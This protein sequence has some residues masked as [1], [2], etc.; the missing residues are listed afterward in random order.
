MEI[1]YHD[2]VKE[3]LSLIPSQVSADF[4][5]GSIKDVI[6]L[7]STEGVKVFVPSNWE[8]LNGVKPIDLEVL[9]DMPTQHRP[10]FRSINPKLFEHAKTY[11][12][13][14]TYFI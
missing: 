13:M 6:K 12:N 1:S 4:I 11:E 9:P 10:K 8:G 7:L 2:A 14:I 3:Y 5:K